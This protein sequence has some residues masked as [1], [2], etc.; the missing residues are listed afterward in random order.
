[1]PQTIAV[2]AA[3][4][5]LPAATSFPIFAVGWISGLKRSI[6]DSIA[7]LINSQIHTSP[8]TQTSIAQ[9][10]V[11]N[12]NQMASKMTIIVTIRWIHVFSWVLSTARMPANAC[13]KLFARRI[14]KRLIN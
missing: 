2:M 9:S 8:I 12:L 10:W 1:M 6:A 13:V 14:K 5:T 11:D 3:M 4:R 7:V